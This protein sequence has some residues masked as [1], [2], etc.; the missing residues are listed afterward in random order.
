MLPRHPASNP[1]GGGLVG[2]LVT[3]AIIV[4]LA[5]VSLSALT[6]AMTGAGNTTSG[7][8]RSFEEQLS[9]ASLGQAF[10]LVERDW[11]GPPQP[12]RLLGTNSPLADTSANFWSAL[13]MGEYAKPEQLVTKNERNP[14]VV[15]ISRYD[16]AAHDPARKRFWDPRFE[17]D[18]VDGSNVSYAHVPLFGERLSTWGRLDASFPLVGS[19]GPAEGTDNPKSFTYGR[20]GTWA[21]FRCYGDGHVSFHQDFGSGRSLADGSPDNVFAMEEGAKGRDAILAFTRAMNGDGP[22]LQWD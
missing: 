9:L 3:M 1:R 22:R 14:A 18:L 2:L 5:A 6:T 17:A 4:V 13:V 12:S 7:S 21:G 10:V 20:D 16:Y 11:G 19:R 15:E 8:V